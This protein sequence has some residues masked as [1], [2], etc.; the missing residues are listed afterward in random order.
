MSVSI[1]SRSS[2]T[3][4]ATSRSGSAL[5]KVRMPLKLIMR[6]RSSSPAANSAAPVKQCRTPIRGRV[7]RPGRDVILQARP[8]CPRPL[9]GCARSTGASGGAP[10]PAGRRTARAAPAPSPA[11]SDSPGRSRRRPR[12]PGRAE[13]ASSPAREGGCIGLVAVETERGKNAAGPCPRRHAS[14][15]WFDVRRA[16]DGQDAE[17]AGG[18]GPVHGRAGI[19]RIGERVEMRVGVEEHRV[20]VFSVRC[21]GEGSSRPVSSQA[22]TGWLLP[23]FPQVVSSA[24]A[25]SARFNSR[26]IFRARAP[27][28]DGGFG[29]GGLLGHGRYSAARLT[30]QV[31]SGIQFGQLLAQHRAGRSPRSSGGRG[32]GPR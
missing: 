24:S 1:S 22:S 14:A 12:P 32:P 2:G 11:G 5:R 25:S 7:A 16:A 31:V 4:R 8:P 29:G 30:E 23:A 20:P 10:G 13:P 3:A 15:A 28:A 9:R 17:D 18:F 21:S 27:V 19:R 26:R 6:P